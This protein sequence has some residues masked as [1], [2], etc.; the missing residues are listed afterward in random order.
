MKRSCSFG[1]NNFCTWVYIVLFFLYLF[2]SLENVVLAE[3]TCCIHLEPFHNACTMKMM[4]AWES[5]EINSILIWAETYA[6]FL[7]KLKNQN[8]NSQ[9]YNK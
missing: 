9:K 8:P 6:A 5:M 3:W 2:I 7:Y 4:V 1:L